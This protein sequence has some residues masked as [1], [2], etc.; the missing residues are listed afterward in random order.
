[1][2]RE[3]NGAI[4]DNESGLSG[5]QDSPNAFRNFIEQ[6]LSDLEDDANL[7]SRIPPAVVDAAWLRYLERLDVQTQAL[8]IHPDEDVWEEELTDDRRAIVEAIARHFTPLAQP[9]F[10][11]LNP[12]E[13]HELVRFVAI[14]TLHLEVN[15]LPVLVPADLFPYLD[16][17]PL[18]ESDDEEGEDEAD[19]PAKLPPWLTAKPTPVAVPARRARQFEWLDLLLVFLLSGVLWLSLYELMAHAGT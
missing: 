6:E 2:T 19:P 12:D 15:R 1:V 13:W 9:Q 4:M 17:R 10:S 5:E 11:S 8:A 7:W 18:D 14:L 3:A 16:W